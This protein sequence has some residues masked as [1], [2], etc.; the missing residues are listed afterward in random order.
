MS[1]TTE[2]IVEALLL[3][4][5]RP[6]S[7]VEILKAFE[8]DRQIDIGDIKAALESLNQFYLDRSIELVKVANGFR[9]KARQE[10]SSWIAKLWETK[11]QKY[12]RAMMETLALIAYKQPI[13]RGEIE[14]VRGVSVSS[15]II[16]NLMDR[17]WIKVVGHRDVP[18]RPSLLSTT[19]DFLDDLNL[20]KL[21]DLPNLPDI[22]NI[23]DEIQM[24]LFSDDQKEEITSA[25][26]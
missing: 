25:Q 4:S 20:R 11:P 6:L 13:T 9:L 15:Q 8:D 17:G 21:S 2:K 14:E 26:E 24:P 7:E 23:P 5:S 19:K 18:G 12:S 22:G 3:S 10:Y 16:R 1:E